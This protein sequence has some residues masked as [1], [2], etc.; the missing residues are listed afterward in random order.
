MPLESSEKSAAPKRASLLLGFFLFLLF[1]SS[2]GWLAWMYASDARLS[3]QYHHAPGCF[4]GTPADPSLPPCRRAT[5]LVTRRWGSDGDLLDLAEQGD[6]PR[7]ESVNDRVWKAA[8]VGSRVSAKIWKGQIVRVRAG[9]WSSVTDDNPG[10][11]ARQNLFLLRELGFLLLLGIVCFPSALANW[12]RQVRGLPVNPENVYTVRA[13]GD[14]WTLSARRYTHIGFLL[15]GLLMLGVIAL[16]VCGLA[17]LSQYLLGLSWPVLAAAWGAFALLAWLGRHSKFL[18][19]RLPYLF[20]LTPIFLGQVLMSRLGDAG[21]ILLFGDRW[22]FDRARDRIQHNDQSTAALSDIASIQLEENKS[23]RG[24]LRRSL[25]LAAKD[26]TEIGA[27]LASWADAEETEYVAQR[28]ADFL[29]LPLQRL[30]ENGG[31]ADPEQTGQQKPVVPLTDSQRLEIPY[32]STFADLCRTELYVFRRR[33]WLILYNLFLLSVTGAYFWLPPYLHQ[34]DYLGAAEL[35]ALMLAGSGALVAA[36]TALGLALTLARRGVDRRCRFVVGADG[37]EDVMPGKTV[38]VPW[39]EVAAIEEQ[40]G[41]L[42]LFRR[43]AKGM[44]GTLAT[45]LPR[46]AFAGPD[47]AR[48]FYDTVVSLWE[49]GRSAEDKPAAQAKGAED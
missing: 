37:Y 24:R 12:F 46:S 38:A 27:S 20:L 17:I 44:L 1:A 15:V 6:N 33:P 47:E 40:G 11:Q 8:P 4:P 3:R 41:D 10:Y 31:E 49:E 14:C 35:V 43:K 26:G 23:T 18:A 13:Q 36:L 9:P 39:R 25:R 2:G 28:L 45:A 32:A 42:Y 22:T 34:G 21:R 16:F 29:G 48:A 5:L 19:L 30:P 7:T